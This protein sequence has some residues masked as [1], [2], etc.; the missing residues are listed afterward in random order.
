M[1]RAM[2]LRHPFRRHEI[3]M[4]PSRHSS[5]E[6][7]IQSPTTL[8]ASSRCNG[9]SDTRLGTVH[10]HLGAVRDTAEWLRCITP[11]ASVTLRG[12]AS[13]RAI[14]KKSLILNACFNSL[15]L[16]LSR[17]LRDSPSKAPILRPTSSS[18]RAVSITEC[19]TLR[20]MT[21]TNL[22]A[23]RRSLLRPTGGVELR[24]LLRSVAS[25]G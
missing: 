12:S 25:R 8:A 4:Q 24:R 19:A 17:S 20:R 7:Y 23:V 16:R 11:L 9:R 21:V 2:A 3:I 13:F 5:R 10:Y 14:G 18:L 1:Q 15:K 6:D 22:R